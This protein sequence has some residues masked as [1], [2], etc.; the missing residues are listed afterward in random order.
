MSGLLAPTTGEVIYDNVDIYKLKDAKRTVLR[1]RAFGFIFQ[2]Y[3]LLPGFTAIENIRLPLL[4]NG[5]KVDLEYEK[6]L[7]EMLQISNRLAHYPS[8]LSGGQQQRVAIARALILRPKIIFADEPTGNLDSASKKEVFD[9]LINCVSA[10]E[11]SLLMVT[12]DE[13]IAER[14]GTLY[15]MEDGKLFIEKEEIGTP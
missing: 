14:V 3:H 2:A 6:Y 7:C 4:L 1:R 10:F 9:L 12:H 5:D 8:E 15:R 11:S 13:S